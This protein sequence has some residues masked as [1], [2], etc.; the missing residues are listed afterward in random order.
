MPKKRLDMS[1]VE[2]LPLLI[3][4]C[5]VAE[6]THAICFVL[7]FI[8]IIIW[9]GVAS[10]V[11]AVLWGLTHIPPIIIQRYNRPRFKTMLKRVS[12]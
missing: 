8:P 4:E 9:S 3:K 5:C 6:A 2:K 1:A 10:V 11:L 7:G 12:K